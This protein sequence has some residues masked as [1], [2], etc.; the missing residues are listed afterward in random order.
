VTSAHAE[1]RTLLEDARERTMALQ[2]RAAALAE[3]V[4][5]DARVSS[6]SQV[7][8]HVERDALNGPPAA[9]EAPTGAPAA[10]EALNRAAE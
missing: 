6:S 3:L 4:D 7:E 10:P 9:P 1:I 8:A 2:A 5:R